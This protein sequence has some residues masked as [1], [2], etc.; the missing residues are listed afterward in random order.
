MALAK[1]PPATRNRNKL[2]MDDYEDL[3][4]YNGDTEHDMWVDFDY[5]ENTGELSGIFD[6]SDMDSYINNLNDWD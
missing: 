3:D 5:N 6:D 2:T 1:R 4:A